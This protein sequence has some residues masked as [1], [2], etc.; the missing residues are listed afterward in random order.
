MNIKRII[1]LLLATVML[2]ALAA[3]NDNAGD[4]DTTDI[5]GNTDNS[6]VDIETVKETIITELSITDAR[7][8][9]A[10]RLLDL[11]GIKEEDITVTSSFVT[12]NAIFP[13]E[14]IM[15]NAVNSDKAEEIAEKLQTH[16]DEVK[17]QSQSYDAENYA[18]AQKC[19]VIT[20][21]LTVALFLSP[22]QDAMVE[23]FNRVAENG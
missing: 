23:I 22:D 12:M 16:L 11:Y 1:A 19:E 14:V 10:P 13:H 8:L 6:V 17:V 9:E 2:M 5:G 3:C 4:T 7:G 21:G 18:I 20:E 15:V